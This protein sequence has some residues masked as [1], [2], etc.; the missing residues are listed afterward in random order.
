MLVLASSA[1]VVSFVRRKADY[2]V[3][4]ARDRGAVHLELVGGELA[5]DIP[6]RVVYYPMSCT[7]LTI[8][9]GS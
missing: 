9:A 3:L 5:L 8:Y 2:T 6:T 1:R 7:T 4:H